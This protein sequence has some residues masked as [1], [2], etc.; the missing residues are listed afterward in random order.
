MSIRLA[1]R[2][3]TVRAG[4]AQGDKSG[5]TQDTIFGPEFLWWL[6]TS[7]TT[8]CNG[9]R[10][11]DRGAQ[12]GF[13][14]ASPLVRALTFGSQLIAVMKHGDQLPATSETDRYSRQHTCQV[15]L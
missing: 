6:R 5:F 4:R 10:P 12:R 15:N 8:D 3:R 11:R 2:I 7:W 14:E 1:R 9:C 13:P